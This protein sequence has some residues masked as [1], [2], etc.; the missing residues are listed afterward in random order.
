MGE[1]KR[2][3]EYWL[4]N[5]KVPT[6]PTDELP[7][8]GAFGHREELTR[9]RFYSEVIAH[10]TDKE[11]HELLV[12]FAREKRMPFMSFGDQLEA[13]ARHLHD[14][15]PVETL[16]NAAKKPQHQ[17]EAEFKLVEIVRE[18]T[19]RYGTGHKAVP[20]ICEGLHQLFPKATREQIEM[21]F[22]A[23]ITEV[24]FNTSRV[25]ETMLTVL[26]QEPN[27]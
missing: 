10:Y 19:K 5:L 25:I 14:G 24:G 8:V 13:M 7:P 16:L 6:S 23:G 9:T 21:G 17:L 1:Q 4:R 2:K 3:R 20:Y 22:K 11:Q 18:G 12:T 26:G 27:A 15:K